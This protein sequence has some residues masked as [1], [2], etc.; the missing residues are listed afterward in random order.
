MLKSIWMKKMKR[1]GLE[2]RWWYIYTM[3]RYSAIKRN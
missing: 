2:Y 3:E 1:H